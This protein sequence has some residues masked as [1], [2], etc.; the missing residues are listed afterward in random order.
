MNF[1]SIVPL[2][3][4]PYLT[5]ADL[6]GR[7][8]ASTLFY[9]GS[10]WQMWLQTEQA[11]RFV[12]V[13]A[14]PAESF[15]FS[16]KPE[17]ENDLCSEFLNF[18][19]QSANALSVMRRFSAIGDDIFNLS[20][21]LAKLPIFH[22]SAT[23]SQG[24]S[25]LAATEVEY[26]LFTCRSVFDLLQEVIKD[27]W[28]TILLRDTTIRKKALKKSFADMTLHGSEMRAAEDIAERYGLP[29]PLAECYAGHAPM[30]LK[31]RQ[32]R[33]D[34]VH[35][36]HRVQTIF[37]GETGFLITNSLGSFRDINIWREPEVIVNGLA[38]LA[39]VLNTDRFGL[40]TDFLAEAFHYQ[41]KHSNRYE[42]VSRRLKLGPAVEG[43][44]EKGIKK[45]LSALLKILHP[46]DSPTDVEFDEY[47]SYAIEC[48]RR[49]KEQMNKRKPDDEFA[50]I[51]L[52]YIDKDGREIVVHCPESAN[53]SATLEPARRRLK[54][55]AQSGEPASAPAQPSA[56][57]KFIVAPS[58]DEIP[59]AISSPQP[60]GPIDR[61]YTIGYG[62]TGH[63]YDTIFGP[64][65]V[66]AK[67]M[68]VEDPYIRAPHQIANFV[69]LCETALKASTVQT[70]TL[71][72]SYDQ[73]TDM[74]DV[75][76]KLDELKQS[77]LEY[78][79]AL[80]VELNANLHDR[81]VRL[82]NGWIIKI[83]RGL[84]FYQ[85]PDGW[86]TVGATD[87][88]LRRCLETKV[89]VF[90]APAGE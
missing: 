68:V 84:D 72:T 45:T 12:K 32:F 26:I 21:S 11:D 65:L 44:D 25:R 49:V 16:A 15:Y 63:S 48:R 47:V 80:N 53:A 43:R 39:P 8:L 52:S 9:D 89:D 50:K 28:E 76:D 54:M 22:S 7:F 23:A 77:L 33:D 56:A 5:K 67:S 1:G 38:P 37:H 18:L 6:S 58:S 30:F 46:A 34:L 31:I 79:V 62:D 82:D 14:W 27:L 10:D 51:D 35:R 36:G 17:N 64:Y 70:I 85:K 60:I 75:R 20:A 87:L 19:A 61:H 66:G 86:F 24:S 55:S 57:E 42:E 4:I 40:I 78:D 29:M 13:H 74:A 83:G 59:T 41:L 81:E 88:N 71:I 3:E 2:S 90:R 73:Q 69:R